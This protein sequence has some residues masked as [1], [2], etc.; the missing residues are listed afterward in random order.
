MCQQPRAAHA[1]R[2]DQLSDLFERLEL[3]EQI[4]AEREEAFIAAAKDVVK[5]TTPVVKGTKK[6]RK[7]KQHPTP[8]PTKAPTHPCPLGLNQQSD[9]DKGFGQV[10][11]E[12]EVEKALTAEEIAKL[13]EDTDP[14]ENVSPSL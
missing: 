7:T 1:L 13:Y 6:R 8:S 9:E 3:V 10:Y 2:S 5:N 12:D 14:D 4:V 11:D